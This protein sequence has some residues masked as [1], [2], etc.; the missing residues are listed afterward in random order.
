MIMTAL[1]RNVFVGRVNEA[2][3]VRLLVFH[4]APAEPPLA[5][6]SFGP[7]VLMLDI[8]MPATTWASAVANASMAQRAS[9]Y[10]EAQAFHNNKPVKPKGEYYVAFFTKNH[11]KEAG[12]LPPG[13][14]SAVKITIGMDAL[15][16]ETGD[17]AE[18]YAV[19]LVEHPL[20]DYLSRYVLSNMGK[21]K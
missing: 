2:G 4:N 9:A 6:K 18:T 1:T 17:N 8:T 7:G 16:P 11:P 20:Y 12:A 15:P 19:N 10:Y 14:L 3:D 13:Y 5:S 21:R